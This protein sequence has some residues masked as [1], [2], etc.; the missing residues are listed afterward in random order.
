M[1]VEEH[2][3]HKPP[4]LVALFRRFLSVAQTF[5]AVEVEATRV[6]V[7]LHGRRRIFGSAKIGKDALRGHL[8]LPIRVDGDPRFTKV[9]S[10]TKSL[11]F[12]RFVLSGDADLDES[13]VRLVERAYRVGA[14]DR[15]A[16]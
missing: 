14:G 7:V 16:R 9:E 8:V 6:G 3:R 1:T 10:L 11:Y 15:A 2:L 4:H 13:F 12:H 5:G